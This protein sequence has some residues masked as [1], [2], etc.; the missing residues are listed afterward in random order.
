MAQASECTHLYSKLARREVD[1]LLL[2]LHQ[3]SGGFLLGESSADGAGLLRPQVERDILLALVEEAEL[4]ALLEVDD[5]QNARNGFPEVVAGDEQCQL[6]EDPSRT[7]KTALQREQVSN[8]HLVELGAGPGD[9]L[10]DA[11]LPQLRL[12]FSQLLDEV[13]LVLGP[14]QTGLDLCCRHDA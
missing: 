11:Q 6:L 5:G 14:Q 7:R 8:L 9:D 12:E 3:H 2:C 10:L 4:G 1:L 13:I